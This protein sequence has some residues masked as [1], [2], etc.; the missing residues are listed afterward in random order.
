MKLNIRLFYK[1]F[2]IVILFI[3][4]LIIAGC[5]FPVLGFLYSARDAK[6]KRDALKTRWLQWFSAI[7]NLHIIKDGELPERRAIFVSNHISWLDIIVIGQYFPAYFVAKSDISS[8]PVIGYLAKQGGTIFIRRGNKQHI[9]TTAEKM[10]WLLKQNGNIVAFPE[11]TT[12]RG[13]EVLHFHSSLFQPALLTRTA[14]QPVALQYQGEA[15]EHAPY[16]GD[17]VFVPHLIKMLALDRIEVRLSFL[18]AIS[19]T[20]KSRHTVSLETRD[21]IWKKIS[22]DLP[23]D[24]SEPQYLKSSRG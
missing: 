8:W 20:G 23:A 7:V 13:D 5:I 21:R 14:I 12:T 3:K 17:D 18:P 6:I 10:V 11:G 22:E 16:V 24:N 4:G 19:S 15:K 1:L 9:K 2:L